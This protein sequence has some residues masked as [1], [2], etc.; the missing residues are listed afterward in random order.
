MPQFSVHLTRATHAQF[1]SY[2]L[3]L[4][5]GEFHLSNSLQLARTAHVDASNFFRGRPDAMAVSGQR[6]GRCRIVARVQL[7]RPAPHWPH[8]SPTPPS[9]RWS[10]GHARPSCVFPQNGA[11]TRGSP[12]WGSKFVRFA[13]DL[14]ST[15]GAVVHL[16]FDLLGARFGHFSAVSTKI[17]SWARPTCQPSSARFGVRVP[18]DSG[19]GVCRMWAPLDQMRPRF[20]Q[21]L[22]GCGEQS[23]RFEDVRPGSSRPTLGRSLDQFRPK[24]L[25]EPT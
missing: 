21:K 15:M 14:G 11:S 10:A 24:P 12:L 18:P 19:C 23:A 9:R 22:A 6:N 17:L 20:F 7:K 5:V 13:V 4:K 1:L 16:G 8:T 25:L 3:I 2:T